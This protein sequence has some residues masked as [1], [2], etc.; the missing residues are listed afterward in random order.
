[1]TAITVV[2]EIDGTGS[3][4]GGVGSRWAVDKEV[5][6]DGRGGNIV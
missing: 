3:Y 4:C 1:M 6:G 5:D 2:G